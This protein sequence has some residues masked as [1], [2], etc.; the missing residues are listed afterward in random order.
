[1]CCIHKHITWAEQRRCRTHAVLSVVIPSQ[2]KPHTPRPVTNIQRR[3]TKRGCNDREKKI[4]K[5][6]PFFLV[7]M[8]KEISV[9]RLCAKTHRRR[10][11]HLVKWKGGGVTGC[12]IKMQLGRSSSKRRQV[13]LRNIVKTV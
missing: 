10:L 9:H 5:M 3:T 1:M 6:C 4:E 2:Q 12:S 11:S 7:G 13:S 8:L